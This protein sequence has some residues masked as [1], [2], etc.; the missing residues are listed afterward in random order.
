MALKIFIS[1]AHI[2]ERDYQRALEPL[3][4]KFHPILLLNVLFMMVVASG[5]LKLSVGM[6]V[7]SMRGRSCIPTSFA[8]MASLKEVL[9]YVEAGVISKISFRRTKKQKHSATKKWVTNLYT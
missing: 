9:L 1:C 5:V 6:V 8:K 2:E 7:H 4:S 3:L